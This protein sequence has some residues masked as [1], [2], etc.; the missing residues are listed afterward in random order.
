MPDGIEL[1]AFADDLAVVAT[2]SLTLERRLREALQ[3]ID[4]WLRERGLDLAIDKTAA[5]L[6]AHRPPSIGNP[7][8]VWLRGVLVPLSPYVKYLGVLL[9]SRHFTVESWQR[10]WGTSKS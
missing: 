5:T 2:H 3:G 4:V 1:V 6:L 9:D 10:E 8:T 7:P